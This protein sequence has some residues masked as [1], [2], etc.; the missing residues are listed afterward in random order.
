MSSSLDVIGLGV[1]GAHRFCL[2]LLHMS[3]ICNFSRTTSSEMLLYLISTVPTNS[4][5]AIVNSALSEESCP[6]NN[7]CLLVL[8][9]LKVSEQSLHTFPTDLL[10]VLRRG[11]NGD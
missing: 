6:R 10:G 2:L 11:A 8:D 9:A 3:F 5:S 1:D 4:Y 7:L